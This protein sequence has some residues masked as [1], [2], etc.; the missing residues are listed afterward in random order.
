[1]TSG[2]KLAGFFGFDSVRIEKTWTEEDV[3]LLK[4][5][6]EIFVNALERKKS[7]EMLQK[8]HDQLEMR[9]RERTNELSKA[10]VLLKD[11]ITEHKK[12]KAELQ[13]YEILISEISDLPYICDTKGNIVFVNYMFNKLT[14]HKREEFLGKSFAPL[15]DEESQKIAIDVYKRTLQGESPQY[16]LYFKETGVLCEYKNHPLKD[17]SGKIIGIIGTARDIT[18]RKRMEESLRKTNQTLRAMI[19]ASPLAIVVFDSYG[20]VKMW[21][22]SAG[23]IFG[24]TEDEVLGQPLPIIPEQDQSE[25][26]MLFNRVLK[27]ESYMGKEVLGRKRNNS[28]IDISISTAPLC[29][30]KGEVVGVVCIMD[31]VTDRKRMI[32]ALR[33]AKEY[34][35]NLIETATVMVVGFDRNGD[36]QVFNRSAEVTTGYKKTELMGKNWFEIVA[37]KDAF[38]TVWQEFQHWQAGGHF[39]NSYENPIITKSGKRRYISWQNTE[40][41]DMGKVVGI[42]S[43]GNDIT[44]HKRKKALIERLRLTSFVNEIG[45]AI[46]E[47]NTM[48]EILQR[49]ATAIVHNLDAA[50]ARIWTLNE[51]ENVLELQASA[52]MYTNIDGAH[53]RI[54]VGKLEI[55]LIAQDRTPYQTNNF[56]NDMRISDKDWAKQE[57]IVAFAGYP[58]I[59]NDHLVGVAAMFSRKPLTEF[60]HKAFASAA[61]I[62]ALGIGRKCTEEALRVSENRYRRLLENLPQRIFHKDRNSVYVSCNENYAMDLRIKPE[63][64]FGKTDYDFHPTE[65][66]DKYR[67]DDKRVM[68]TEKTEDIEEKYMKDGRELIIHTVKTPLKDEEGNI[69]GILGIFWD[70]TEKITLQIET[71]RTRHLASLGELAAGVA[72]EINNP[73]TGIINYSQIIINKCDKGS[74]ESDIAK[75]ILK[76]GDRI[77]VIVRG[78][79]SFARADGKKEKKSPVSIHD[80]LSDTFTLTEA[81]MR[82][83]NIILQLHVPPELPQIIANHHQIQQ[84]FLN[85]VSNARY[86]L[87]QRYQEAHDNKI[88]NVSCEKII[89][90]NCPYVKIVFHDHG[91]GIPTDIMSKIMSPFFTT[92]PTGKGTGLGLSISHGIVSDHGGKLVIDSTEGGYTKV[93]ITLPA[94]A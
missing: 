80:I 61:N 76:E 1:M 24:W 6:G 21:N 54:P 82:K 12:A 22:P 57:K 73:I 29:D 13:K 85:I 46:N 83:D 79:L 87:N 44:E 59:V 50:F 94:I 52:G 40:V 3:T 91:T 62:I 45:T 86:A 71:V 47:G 51:K 43:F 69:V 14:G 92:K 89:V 7:W 17:E 41:R 20:N 75:R 34:A 74:R 9:V 25:F 68:E 19:L 77:A 15:F 53:G 42:I 93:S 39:P 84:V 30:A 2:G 56:G 32:E 90:D 23:R 31:D 48:R 11:E 4:M 72:H 16:E 58:L 78:L 8:A 67:S 88:L 81:Q 5:I 55:G 28:P 37:P 49:C 27:G 26:R 10:N 66:A 65:L 70:I 60:T 38:P 63:E 33:Q 36:I 64:I 18:E 35:E